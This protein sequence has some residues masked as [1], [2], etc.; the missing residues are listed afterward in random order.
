MEARLQFTD[1]M[2]LL[3]I[4]DWVFLPAPYINF[5]KFED[6][7][8]SLPVYCNTNSEKEVVSCRRNKQN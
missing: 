6:E 8:F 7:N 3:E 5:R 2:A 1:I 4:F